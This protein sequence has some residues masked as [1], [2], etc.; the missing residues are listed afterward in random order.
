MIAQERSRNRRGGIF[1][2]EQGLGKTFTIIAFLQFAKIRLER[3][4]RPT[5]IV[6]P[7]SVLNQWCAEVSDKLSKE[8]ALAV[9]QYYGSEK[10]QIR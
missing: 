2:G 9:Y 3:R 5:L 4:K 8:H 1:A 10:K 7:K 6:V